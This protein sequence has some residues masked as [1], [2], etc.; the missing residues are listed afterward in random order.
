MEPKI[1]RKEP[2]WEQV[3]NAMKVWG[4]STLKIG[5]NSVVFE[6]GVQKIIAR[7]TFEDNWKVEY[8]FGNNMD[9][10]TGITNSFFAKREAME[11]G[12]LK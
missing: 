10:M 1:E 8:Y 3:A 4:W 9:D 6:K 2:K 7:R 12:I 5:N 11:L